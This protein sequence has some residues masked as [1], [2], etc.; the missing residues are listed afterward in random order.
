MTELTDLKFPTVTSKMPFLRGAVVATNLIAPQHKIVDGISRLIVK[1]DLPSLAKKDRLLEITAAETML[2]ETWQVV[3]EGIEA[4][5]VTESNAYKLYGRMAARTVLLL[6]K[7]WRE[8]PEQKEYAKLSAVKAQFKLEWEKLGK[9]IGTSM[10]K[11]DQPEPEAAQKSISLQE[12]G[13]ACWNSNRAGFNVGLFSRSK[14]LRTY[15]ASAT[16]MGSPSPLIGSHSSL[17]M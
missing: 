3:T 12:A 9:G 2:A 14:A 5:P 17:T 4:D 6:T 1:S 7:K 16:W 15:T 11:V 8:G 10:K 13:S